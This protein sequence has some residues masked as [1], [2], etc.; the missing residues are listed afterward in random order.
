MKFVQYVCIE[1]SEGVILVSD[2][3]LKLT[4]CG[5]TYLVGC[6]SLENMPFK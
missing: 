3:K 2:M 5:L 4:V 6:N 1:I